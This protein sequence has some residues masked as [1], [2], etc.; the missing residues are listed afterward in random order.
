MHQFHGR[1]EPLG[2][3]LL[4]CQTANLEVCSGWVANMCRQWFTGNVV[5][6][7]RLGKKKFRQ[8]TRR[9]PGEARLVAHFLKREASI[10]AETVPAEKCRFGRHAVNRLDGI[11]N[12]FFDKS[13]AFHLGPLRKLSKIEPKCVKSFVGLVTKKSLTDTLLG[14]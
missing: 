10:A 1:T 7:E 11:T 2:D 9:Q 13:D 5:E 14:V 12:K 8:A 6:I 4:E 3:L